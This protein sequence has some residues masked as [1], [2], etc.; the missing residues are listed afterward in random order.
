MKPEPA[1]TPGETVPI[2]SD[3]VLELPDELSQALRS[4]VIRLDVVEVNRLIH[5]LKESNPNAA[6]VLSQLANNLEYS[7]MLRLIDE[8]K[9]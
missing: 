8:G 1:G 3:A 5:S 4:A 6:A 9:E 2:R 7:Q